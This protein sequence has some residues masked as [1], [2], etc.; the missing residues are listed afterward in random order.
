MSNE[1][2][3]RSNLVD[4]GR[5]TTVF[6]VKGWVKIHSDTEPRENIFSYSPWWI[7]TRHGVKEVEILEC[8]PHGN[9]LVAHIKGIDDRDAARE[10]CQVNIAVERD[11]ISELEPGEYY[12]YQ[13]EGL[14][15]IT[16]FNGQKLRLG[17]VSRMLETGANDVLVIQGDSDSIDQKERLVPYVP[18]QF[19]TSI[20]L[21]AGEIIVD[22]DPDF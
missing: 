9:T 11:Q 21:D 13:L 12:W 3:K 15:V 8:R 17:T 14:V 2:K 5:I 7:K 19:I 22:W 18:E 10:I 20:D 16:Q 4:V 6:G 1:P